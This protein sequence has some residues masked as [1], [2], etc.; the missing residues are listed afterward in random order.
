MLVEDFQHRPEVSP[1]A[2]C[3]GHTLMSNLMFT[4]VLSIFPVRHDPSCHTLYV[5][6]GPSLNTMAPS[7]T[8]YGKTPTNVAPLT[9]IRSPGLMYVSD[10]R[11]IDTLPPSKLSSMA[12]L[13]RPPVHDPSVST[14]PVNLRPSVRGSG[15]VTAVAGGWLFAQPAKTSSIRKIHLDIFEHSFCVVCFNY[16]TCIC[17]SQSV[18]LGIITQCRTV[19]ET[20]WTSA[21]RGM[22][23]KSL[24]PK[25]QRG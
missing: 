24:Q 6:S 17:R 21:L 3:V 20:L 22:L 2:Q 19:K 23:G 8:V 12:A 7:G 18:L 16:A 5:L 11:R 25:I 15:F 1:T 9:N 4:R 14:F 13:H 10:K